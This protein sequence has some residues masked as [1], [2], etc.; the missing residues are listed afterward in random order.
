MPY[1]GLSYRK[2]HSARLV[3]YVVNPE[4]TED[5]ALVTAVGCTAATAG[6]EMTAVR[7]AFQKEGG[8]HIFHLIQDFLPD[9]VTPGLAHMIGNRLARELL[10]DRQ[11]L[12][13]THT[14]REHVHNH[15]LFNAVSDRNGRRFNGK[16]WEIK[17]EIKKCSDRICREAGISVE[18]QARKEGYVRCYVEKTLHRAGHLTNRDLVRRDLKEAAAL[19]ENVRDLYE[20]M[21]GRGYLVETDGEFPVFIPSGS[22]RKFCAWKDGK[23]MREA[24]LEQE[25][26]RLLN[27]PETVLPERRRLPDYRP[28][29]SLAG[30]QRLYDVWIHTVDAAGREGI[31]VPNVPLDGYEVAR[32][33]RYRKQAEYLKRSAIVR[34]EELEDRIGNLSEEIDRLE[35]RQHA[36]ISRK[37]E[38]W[39]LNNLLDRIEQYEKE[40]AGGVRE[41]LRL[42]EEEEWFR[43]AQRC[44]GTRDPDQIRRNWTENQEQRREVADA[45]R[46]LRNER[47]FCTGIREDAGTIRAWLEEIERGR[48]RERKRSLLQE[49]AE[50]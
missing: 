31:H 40:S 35:E 39:K 32:L 27:D 33:G 43:E 1:I 4:K 15:I 36:L 23:R 12:V 22:D 28:P 2:D 41:M 29:E 49:Q 11:Y 6:E 30:L 20:I 47:R 50:R 7:K 46:S 42:K 16:L 17:D 34:E 10:D 14:D 44:I 18:F 21:E 48:E 19:S 24:D 26:Q 8:V 45:L 25:I 38:A 3:R 5:P 13:A 37:V 9:A